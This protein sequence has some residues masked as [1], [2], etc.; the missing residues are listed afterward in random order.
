[1]VKIKLKRSFWSGEIKGIEVD[2]RACDVEDAASYVTQL[3]YHMERRGVD[4][5]SSDYG[6]HD[7]LLK[8]KYDKEL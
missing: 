7:A 4:K 3:E 6:V 2:G 5:I 1:M 8:L